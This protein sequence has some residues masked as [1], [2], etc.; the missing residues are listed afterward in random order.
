[1]AGLMVVI[2]GVRYRRHDAER[3]GLLDKGNAGPARAV[4]TAT[5]TPEP[6]GDELEAGD[7]SAED[8]GEDAPVKARKPVNKARRP[9][10][11]ARAGK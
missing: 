10:N 1:M 2:D 8:D 4:T 7:G 6:D 9:V 5:V 3:L 11:K